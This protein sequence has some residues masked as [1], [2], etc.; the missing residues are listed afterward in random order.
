MKNIKLVGKILAIGLIS[1]L[2]SVSA[3]A[4]NP[5]LDAKF[6][7]IKGWAADPAI[8]KAVEAQNSAPSAEVKGMTQ[9]KWKAAGVMDPF[10]RGL[11]KNEA[12]AFLK[13]KMGGDA[14]VAEAFVSAADGSKVGLT[15]KTSSWSHK[16]KPKHDLPMA[17][18]DWTGEEEM[19]ESTGTKTI[20]IA[21]PV[22]S[23]GKPIGSLVVGFAVSKLK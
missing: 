22:L 15:S 1:A 7:E 20:Q 6:K 16:G 21:V 17:G 4:A 9:D 2:F 14:S 11:S 23:G 19:D 5:K 13:A 18:K 8:V 10:V 3:L 12:G